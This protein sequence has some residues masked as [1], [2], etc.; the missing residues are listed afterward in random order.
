MNNLYSR[1]PF[2]ETDTTADFAPEALKQCFEAGHSGAERAHRLDLAKSTAN[3]YR[4]V[5]EAQ[6]E[7]NAVDN[8]Y[9]ERFQRYCT[10]YVEDMFTTELTTDDGLQDAVDGAAADNPQLQ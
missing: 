10:G 4:R 8:Q 5:F 9:Y 6:A 3:R 7:S 1:L 2:R